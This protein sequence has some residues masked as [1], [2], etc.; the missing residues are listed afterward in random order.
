[1][2]PLWMEVRYRTGISIDEK[3]WFT[4]PPSSSY[5]AC[6]AVKCA[7]LQN[8]NFE[9]QMFCMLQRGAMQQ[10]KNIAAMAVL[11]E[12]AEQMPPDFDRTRFQADLIN[13][14]GM[15]AFRKDLEE[16]KLLGIERFPSLKLSARNKTILIKGYRPWENLAQAMEKLKQ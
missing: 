8:R 14:K 16:I 12:I 13:G 7:G 6:I 3:I 11:K 5:P 9:E 2:G 1:M 10:Q 15:E 4:N